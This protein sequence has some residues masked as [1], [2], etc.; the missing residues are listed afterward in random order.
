M[1]VLF[2][3]AVSGSSSVDTGD[4]GH[5]LRFRSGSYLTRTPG[6]SGSRRK[7][8][9][10]MWVK[11][12]ALGVF[13]RTFGAD[14]IGST[15]FCVGFNTNN[16]LEIRDFSGGYLIQGIST[17]VFR[18]TTSFIHL[19]VA[20]DT[21]QAT[22]AN[23]VKAYVNG[24]QITAWDTSTYSGVHDLQINDTRKQSFGVYLVSGSPSAPFDYGLDYLARAC[25]VTGSQEA[26]TSF[27]YLNTEINEWVSKSQSAVKA[28]VDAGG[29]NSFML[30]FDDATSLT[31][32]GYDKSSKGNNW[33]LNN[34]SL[35][36]GT[37]YDHMLDVPGNSFCTAS[38][39]D[40][41]ANP[42]SSSLT[43]ANLKSACSVVSGG[44]STCGTMALPAGKWVWE[45]VPT[46]IG[47]GLVLGI[48][49]RTSGAPSSTAVGYT[50]DGTKNIAGT[51]T[52][53]GSSYAA[54]D[55]I[56]VQVDT[57]ANTIEFF[58]NDVSQ[59]VITNA[60]YVVP[61]C[62]P[63]H[64]NNTSSG[65]STVQ[66]MYGQAPLHA[67][68]AWRS[69]A[70]GYFRHTPTTG[71]K[72]LCQRNLPDPAILNPE[73]HFDVKLDT[74]VNIKTTMDALFSGNVFEWIKDRANSNNHQLA[75]VNRGLTAILQSNITAAETTYSAPSGSSVGWGWKM[76]GAAVTNNN[77]SIS[78]QVSAN[79]LAGQS[80][81][82]Y[83]GNFTAGATVGHGLNSASE[84][85]IIKNR[86]A[87]YDW[88]VFHTKAG[89]ANALLL[90]LTNAA[91][92]SSYFNGVAPG[93]TTFA[94]GAQNQSNQN[95]AKHVALCFHS[96]P[97]YSKVGSYTGNGNAD[98]PYVECGFK[99]K[100][101]LIKAVIAGD[102]NSDWIIY[103]TIR[104]PY[105]VADDRLW[106]N[107]DYA[108]AASAVYELDILSSG[109]KPRN[110]MAN[111]GFN[112][113]GVTYVFYAIADVAGKFAL[114]R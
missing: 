37:T 58:K 77:G 93:A 6:S 65:G 66:H 43:E 97:G 48:T 39:I 53:Y 40:L 33:T 26:P 102:S 94:L 49:S 106:A 1:S 87:A 42:G 38:P 24:T 19:V 60:T 74:G 28:V 21:D 44:S 75:D 27:A 76:G 72:A 16:K 111:Y 3:G 88:P 67:S 64:W 10:S 109:F 83:A 95:T 79:V 15:T 57:V 22:F 101:V 105:N 100:Y 71:F 47:N 80:V 114:G 104:S 91:G 70:G 34:F 29:T 86:D 98:G 107:R 20:F 63:L 13:Q 99:P 52:A 25:I 8:T 23:G 51:G 50:F 18:D 89:A 61:G 73:L 36:A 84:L 12:C 14:D 59:G 45:Y 46:T 2:N 78:S 108:E 113:S 110:G 112:T 32:L 4:I 62:K 54:N 55:V 68:A 69:D 35:T 30:D 11:R 82:T 9:V 31:T 103:D 7:L 41:G 85:V 90:N 92:A 5:S 17:Q 96:V 81:V 56:R